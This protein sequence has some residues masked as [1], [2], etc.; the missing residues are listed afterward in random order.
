MTAYVCEVQN[1]GRRFSVSSNL[2]RHE[3]V[4]LYF[5]DRSS[6]EAD[7]EGHVKYLQNGEGRH[8]PSPP[9]VVAPT[10]PT[11][12]HPSYENV[13]LQRDLMSDDPYRLASPSD[14]SSGSEHRRSVSY[15]EIRSSLKH[16]NPSPPTMSQPEYPPYHL[17]SYPIQ[18][19]SGVGHHQ[20]DQ[21]QYQ[22][23]HPTNEDYIPVSLPQPFPS[24]NVDFLES[25]PGM[26]LESYQV[27]SGVKAVQAPVIGSFPPKEGTRNDY[28]SVSI[29][30]QG[31]A[32]IEP[33]FGRQGIE[34][35]WY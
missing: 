2:K 7:S 6:D 24:T 22:Y 20:H 4:S 13:S 34:V 21:Y 30:G 3:K 5:F 11:A 10:E 9:L 15:S 29:E 26:K 18:Y 19:P 8:D 28:T 16:S 23:P 12:N 17:D 31:E 32:R 25:G 1:C 35:L 27:V 33:G 14:K